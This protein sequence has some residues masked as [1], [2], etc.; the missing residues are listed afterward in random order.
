MT[1]I[2]PLFLVIPLVASLLASRSK[3]NSE[4]DLKADTAFSTTLELETDGTSN[5]SDRFLPLD[6]L[7]IEAS[8]TAGYRLD[9]PFA[10]AI[11]GKTEDKG[12]GADAVHDEAEWMGNE[13]VIRL[14]QLL[15]V[16]QRLKDACETQCKSYRHNSAT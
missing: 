2:D 8:R 9:E 13:D 1:P 4:K 5:R 11:K 6:D 14:C 15:S 3:S 12:D 7:I 16:R 10:D